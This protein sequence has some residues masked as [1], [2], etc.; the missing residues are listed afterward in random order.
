MGVL[1]LLSCWSHTHKHTPP[2]P[3]RPSNPANL[4]STVSQQSEDAN[5]IL[6][7]ACLFL[8]SLLCHYS[9]CVTCVIYSAMWLQL[10]NHNTDVLILILNINVLFTSLCSLLL[11]LLVVVVVLI[12]VV[13]VQFALINILCIN[14][15]LCCINKVAYSIKVTT[16]A[17]ILDSS[18]FLV[19][20]P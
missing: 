11:F 2:P 4:I 14:H 8:S 10:E 1:H 17:C 18:F 3:S 9:D 7:S 13:V 15:L 6:Q 20:V 19:S 5:D 16:M 12:V